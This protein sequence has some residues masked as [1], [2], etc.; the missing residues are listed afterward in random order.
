M[1]IDAVWYTR[2]PVPT[3]FSQA[4]RP[5]WI[6]KEFAPDQIWVISLLSSLTRTT[7]KFHFV[8]TQLNSFRP[9]GTFFRCR[10]SRKRMMFG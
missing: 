6:D 1:P 7:R 5:R 8:H 9:G 2:C 10:P 4:I 3:A